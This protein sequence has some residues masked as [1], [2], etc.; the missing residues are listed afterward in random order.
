MENM[1][2]E[3]ENKRLQTDG[4][5]DIQTAKQRNRRSAQLR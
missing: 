1:P 5:T 2:L 4:W 3:N